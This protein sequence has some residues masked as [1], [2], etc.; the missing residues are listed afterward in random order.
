MYH[1]FSDRSVTVSNS[2]RA[3]LLIDSVVNKRS[4]KLSGAKEALRFVLDG[5]LQT[6]VH[7]A[8]LFFLLAF[9]AFESLC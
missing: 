5:C 2:A 8:L 7:Q 3:G 4:S 9:L 6:A 1:F